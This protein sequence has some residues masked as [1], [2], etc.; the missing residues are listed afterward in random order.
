MTYII[1]SDRELNQVVSPRL[2]AATPEYN[3]N[4]INQLNNVLR[5]YFNQLDNILGQLKGST[6]IVDLAFPHGSFLNTASQS[7]TINAALVVAFNTT[8]LSSEITLVSNSKIT[9][10]RA[11][12][13]NLQFKIQYQNTDT[14]IHDANIWLRKNG[15][16]IAD[17]NGAVA[18]P[19]YHGSENGRTI[20]GW[21]YVVEM[22]ANDYLQLI[23][24]TDN[25]AVTITAYPVRTVPIGPATPSVA[26]TMTYVSAVTA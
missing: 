24:S 7:T 18:V 1:T 13:Y 15:V 16:D 4:Y 10:A 5:L 19:N 8:D 20:A 22:D 25:A 23:W 11:G 21:N 9:V 2:P 6:A 26:A 14:Q 17:S 12:V 3:S